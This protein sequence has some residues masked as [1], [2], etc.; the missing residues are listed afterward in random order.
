MG[1]SSTAEWHAFPERHRHL[2]E[3]S[4]ELK[5]HW[6]TQDER[7]FFEENGYLVVHDAL[8][9][10]QVERLNGALNRCEHDATNT[11][12]P[13]NREDILGM[14]EAFVELIDAPPVFAK[15]C[16]LLGWNICV[17]HTHYNIRPPHCDVAGFSYLWHRDGGVVHMD[18]QGRV[19]LMAVKVG[20]YLT[21]LSRPGMGQTYVIPHLHT[22]RLQNIGPNDPPPPEA[23][24]LV[25]P[26]GSAVLFRQ[27][28]H[29]SKGSPNVSDV[30]RKAVFIQWA[31]RWL[32][33]MD[34]MT[35]DPLRDR[36]TDPVRRQLLGLI[37]NRFDPTAEERYYPIPSDIPLAEVLMREV[38][39]ELLHEIG[40]EAHRYLRN[41]VVDQYLDLSNIR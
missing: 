26:A 7:A 19:P 33:P 20:F 40:P 21:D 4:M 17:N 5:R 12:Q 41:C 2:S 32:R 14:D 1:S 38:G 24:P 13:R 25:V 30:V 15:I 34:R 35:V 10:E 29:H 3:D 6:P 27:G 37:P 11:N 36:V 18:L 31:F 8:T 22:A 23:V 28:V 9:Q 39:P 16:G